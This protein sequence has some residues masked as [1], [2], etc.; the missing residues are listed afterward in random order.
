ML[1]SNRVG[2]R[3]P[4]IEQLDTGLLLAV[5]MF[6]VYGDSDRFTDYEIQHDDLRATIDT[7]EL[8]SFYKVGGGDLL[9]HIPQVLG[10]RE[11]EE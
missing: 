3:T 10:L 6:R 4:Y 1:P 8:A 5:M 11:M 7:G 9:D 2:R